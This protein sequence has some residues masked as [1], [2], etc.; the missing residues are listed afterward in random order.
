MR[1]VRLW[2]RARPSPRRRISARLF[3]MRSSKGV[4]RAS[5]ETNLKLAEKEDVSGQICVALPYGT[6]IYIYIRIDS[7]LTM[8]WW[9][10]NGDCLFRQYHHHH[11]HHHHPHHHLL[12][13]PHHHHQQRGFK[14]LNTEHIGMCFVFFKNPYIRA[15]STDPSHPH[16]TDG[17]HGLQIS[18]YVLNSDLK[19]NVHRKCRTCHFMFHLTADAFR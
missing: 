19:I 18:S 9:K 5:Q 13:H 17:Q 14:V 11:H 3:W 4:S 6:Y 10:S 7:D 8:V 1:F 12:L 16:H 15:P 2:G